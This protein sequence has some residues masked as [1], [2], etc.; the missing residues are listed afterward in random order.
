MVMYQQG[1]KWLDTRYEILMLRH[2][3]VTLKRDIF[4]AP[5][6]NSGKER[7]RERESIKRQRE[8]LALSK[9][10][11]NIIATVTILASTGLGH[12]RMLQVVDGLPQEIN[13]N[14]TC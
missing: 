13:K 4:T 5:K 8:L 9:S 2:G 12:T 10:T 7:K 3:L 11:K 14:L 6:Q 1:D